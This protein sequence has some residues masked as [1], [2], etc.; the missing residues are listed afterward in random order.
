MS[1]LKRIKFSL[2]ILLMSSTAF[3]ED[4]LDK[5]KQ[6]QN[7]TYSIIIKSYEISGTENIKNLNNDE[8]VSKINDWKKDKS[9]VVKETKYTFNDLRLLFLD[10]VTESAINDK[11]NNEKLSLYTAYSGKGIVIGLQY[12]TKIFSYETRNIEI[13]KK[14]SPIFTKETS[15]SSIILTAFYEKKN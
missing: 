6:E 9:I 14:E 12:I 4:V 15:G 13:S 5:N 11:F 3:G 7:G 8:I 10:S 1:I 2:I